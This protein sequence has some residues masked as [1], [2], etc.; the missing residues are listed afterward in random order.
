MSNVVY[1]N[2]VYSNHV[3]TSPGKPCGGEVWHSPS[4]RRG[5]LKGFQENAMF[6]WLKSD[7]LVSSRLEP[8]LAYTFCGT[9]WHGVTSSVQTSGIGGEVRHG[10]TSGV[11]H[12]EDNMSDLTRGDVTA[13]VSSVCVCIYIYNVDLSLSLSMY[14]YIYIYTYTCM[15][16][17]AR[18]YCKW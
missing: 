2:H 4:Y 11:S 6:K 16:I 14:T 12:Q 13:V 9:V 15:I 3:F 7:A 10:A 17:L 1:S 8:L 5:T 18:V